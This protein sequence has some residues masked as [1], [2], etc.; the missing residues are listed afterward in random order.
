MNKESGDAKTIWGLVLVIVG[1][2]IFIP[3]YIYYIV[4]SGYAPESVINYGNIANDVE[5]AKS[6]LPILPIAFGV[7]L[8]GFIFGVLNYRPIVM[9]KKGT[10]DERQKV[11]ITVLAG[12]ILCASLLVVPAVYAML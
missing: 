3:G 2:A 11:A 1:A 6:L 7:G 9:E 10:D 8:T 12:L 4:C 5:R